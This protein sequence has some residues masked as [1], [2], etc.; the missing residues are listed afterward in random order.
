[1]EKVEWPLFGDIGDEGNGAAKDNHGFWPAHLG[2]DGAT[3][4]SNFLKK[5][6]NICEMF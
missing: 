1:M 5:L 4:F 3:L 2:D 6:C